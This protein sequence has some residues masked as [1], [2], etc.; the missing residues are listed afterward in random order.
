MK[1][2][3]SK[4]SI[5]FVGGAY[6]RQKFNRALSNFLYNFFYIIGNIVNTTIP[7]LEGTCLFAF[8]AS[9]GFFFSLCNMFTIKNQICKNI[10]YLYLYLSWNNEE[11]G[12]FGNV[13]GYDTGYPACS[14]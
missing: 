14:G 3:I 1:E 13:S 11:S 6:I 2:H 8:F 5:V 9:I 7:N 4:K 12:S 10:C